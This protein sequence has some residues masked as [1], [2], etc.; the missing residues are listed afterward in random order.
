MPSVLQHLKWKA[1]AD[2]QKDS[3]MEDQNETKGRE[4]A[5]GT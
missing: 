5:K 1:L 3:P 2:G 4:G